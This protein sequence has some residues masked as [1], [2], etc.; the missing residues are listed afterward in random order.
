MNLFKCMSRVVY[1]IM[2]CFFII[3]ILTVSK[4]PIEK[5]LS[6]HN[7]WILMERSLTDN[8]FVIWFRQTLLFLWKSTH[9]WNDFVLL[10]VFAAIQLEGIL[11]T[12]LS[13][14][15]TTVNFK[16]LYCILKKNRCGIHNHVNLPLPN[17]SLFILLLKKDFNIWPFK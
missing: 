9:P 2:P 8:I 10:I 12:C 3:F 15:V 1:Q 13:F 5:E 17:W 4:C 7:A 14:R 6:A 16:T 11:S